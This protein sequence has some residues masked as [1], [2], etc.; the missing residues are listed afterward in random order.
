MRRFYILTLLM[1]LTPLHA[2]TGEDAHRK[3]MDR[4]TIAALKKAGANLELPH[5]IEHHFVA[6]DRACR[7]QIIKDDLS[8]GYEASELTE[9]VNEGGAPYW[10]F[11]L[12]K[13]VVPNEDAI[14]AET[15]CMTTLALKHSA[16]YD[17][18]GCNVEK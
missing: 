4:Q 16:E 10:Y 5:L 9:G 6:S 18:W 13:K 17:G 12:K 2:A 7:D 1:L 3:E 15:L 8:A 14:F 11:D